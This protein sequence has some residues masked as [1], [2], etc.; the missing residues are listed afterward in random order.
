MKMYI[1]TMDKRFGGEVFKFEDAKKAAR[2]AEKLI[3]GSYRITDDAGNKY[4]IN[5]FGKCS[6]LTK[7]EE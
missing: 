4:W 2:K 1:I 5:R 7:T 3:G 6:I